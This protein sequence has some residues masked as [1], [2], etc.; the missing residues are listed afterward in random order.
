L[1]RLSCHCFEESFFHKKEK[2]EKWEGGAPEASQETC[3]CISLCSAPSVE[4]RRMMAVAAFG[5]PD[6]PVFG[7]GCGLV[8]GNES[9]R[10]SS[11]LNFPYPKIWFS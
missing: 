5:P 3:L 6:F 8:F 2:P 10:R 1:A 4:G 9:W 11:E 7:L